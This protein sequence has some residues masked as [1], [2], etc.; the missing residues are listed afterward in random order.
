ML[1]DLVEESLIQLNIEASNREDAIRKA[2]QPLVNAGKI[3]NRYID[4]IIRSLHEVGPY[5]VIVP[6]VAMPHARP[7]EGAMQNAI[8]ITVL[9]TP[10]IFGNESNDPVKYLFTLSATGNQ[11]HLET[12]AELANLIEDQAF[13]ELLDQATSAKDVM[14]FLNH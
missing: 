8:G 12:L 11:E 7:E 9:K 10:V 13:F 6:Q 5:F 4:N 14:D 3:E 2:A 1:K